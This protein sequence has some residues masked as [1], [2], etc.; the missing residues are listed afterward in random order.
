VTSRLTRE[1][2]ASVLRQLHALAAVEDALARERIRE[3]EAEVGARVT[4]AER[5]ALYGAAPPLAVSRAVGD[6]LYALT[7]VRRP[8]SAVEFGASTIYLAA[9][10]RDV[11][12]GF[13]VS[14]ELLAEKA[15]AASA[16]L[17]AAG[18]GDL[19]ELRVGDARETL[20][21]VGGPVDLLF[22]D[23]RNDLYLDVLRLLEPVLAPDA[24]VLADLSAGDPDLAP[25][26][27]HVRDAD[28]AY[29]S[30]TL[31][32]EPGLEVSVLKASGARPVDAADEA[33]G[34]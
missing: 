29:R 13:L 10:L 18:L 31:L 14:T 17:A 32:P 4:N 19:V 6:L 8:S 11:G 24:L 15:S 22:L 20:R 23:G 34:G 30:L 25:Y 12:G 21:D 16:N 1:P 5:Y 27:D 33:R 2:V 9:A 7:C 3:R 26:L 28:G